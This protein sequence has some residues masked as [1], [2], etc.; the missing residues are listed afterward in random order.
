MQ[1]EGVAGLVWQSLGCARSRPATRVVSHRPCC[2]APHAR[3][4]ICI[5]RLQHERIVLTF[6][7]IIKGD[8][9]KAAARDTRREAH[10]P[11]QRKR[12][13]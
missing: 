11:S 9:H 13:A 7:V 5:A 12:F 8:G 4:G 10:G 6:H 3:C 1:A 2:T